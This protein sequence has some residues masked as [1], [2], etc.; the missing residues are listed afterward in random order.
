LGSA[1]PGPESKPLPPILGCPPGPLAA[2]GLRG[3]GPPWTG[4]GA[5]G[6]LPELASAKPVAV[7]APSAPEP[8]RPAAASS[9][10]ILSARIPRAGRIAGPGAWPRRVLTWKPGAV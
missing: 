9:L 7:A 4:P 6:P 8:G 5:F 1:G 3:A 2:P 10:P